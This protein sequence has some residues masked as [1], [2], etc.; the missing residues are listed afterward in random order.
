MPRSVC[1]RRRLR[2]SRPCIR[3][4]SW[5]PSDFDRHARFVASARKFLFPPGLVREKPCRAFLPGRE[6]QRRADRTLFR[7][8]RAFGE[9][10]LFRLVAFLYSNLHFAKLLTALT[11]LSL[12]IYSSD[13]WLY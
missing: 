4:A 9:C 13:I 1:G 5:R 8:R 11:P 2:E 6:F 7:S 10:F 3:P 12:F